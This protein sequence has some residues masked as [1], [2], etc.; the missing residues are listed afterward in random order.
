MSKLALH[1]PAQDSPVRTRWQQALPRFHAGYANGDGLGFRLPGP[2]LP[3]SPSTAGF[4]PG[5]EGPFQPRERD[6]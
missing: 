1:R 3:D 5:S 4:A 2:N 6:D